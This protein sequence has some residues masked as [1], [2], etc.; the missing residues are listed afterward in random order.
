MGNMISQSHDNVSQMGNF[1][2]Q[3]ITPILGRKSEIMVNYHNIPHLD[4]GY[5]CK[6]A[7]CNFIYGFTAKI[8]GEFSRIRHICFNQMLRLV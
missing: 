1:S 7:L 4:Q 2:I 8:M 5:M 6:Y 3:N